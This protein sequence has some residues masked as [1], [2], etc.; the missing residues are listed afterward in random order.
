MIKTCRICGSEFETIQYG[1]SR[2]YCFEC[3]PQTDDINKRT[4]YKRTAFKKEGVRLLGGKCL[5]CGENRHYA[6]CFHHLDPKQKVDTP[7]RLIANSQ[8]EDLL[9]EIQKCILL[10]ANCH[11]EFHF[12]EAHQGLTIEEYVDLNQEFKVSDT[13]I[14]D[15]KTIEIIAKQ[16]Q[17]KYTHCS[18]C[19]EVLSSENTTGL[20]LSCYHKSTRKVV[21]RPEP[22]ELAQEI[23]SM[24]FCAV[25]RKYGVSDNAIR[26]WCK[27]YNMPTKKEELHTWLEERQHK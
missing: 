13:I 6:L 2:Q 27:A 26:K 3:V 12:L 4:L 21:D 10:C 23:L 8:F 19:G 1:N 18:Q 14:R 22:I 16:K 20:C 9:I 11:Q 15:K 25:G 24:G 7:S 17:G 5:K